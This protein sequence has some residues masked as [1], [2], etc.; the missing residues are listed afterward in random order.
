MRGVIAPQGNL[1]LAAVLPVALALAISSAP[2]LPAGPM[3]VLHQYASVALSP[4]GKLIASVETVRKPNATTEEHGAVVVRGI[5]GEVHAR[6][7]PCAKCR[8]ADIAWSSEGNRFAF[9]ASADGVATLYGATADT[10]HK[11]RSTGAPDSFTLTKVVDVKGLIASPRWSPDDR[12][13]AVLATVGAHKESGATRAGAREVGEIGES[14]DSQRIAT[15]GASGG[16][17]KF[18]SPDG[19]FVYEYGWMPDGRGFLG[20]AARGNGDDNWWIAKLQFFALDGSAKVVAAPSMQMDF[21][22]VSPDGRKVAFIGGLMSD[23]GSVGGDIYIV[24][25]DGGVPLDITPDFKGS[26]TSIQWRGNQLI[27]SL[28]VG[29]QMGTAQVDPSGKGVRRVHVQAATYG[30]ADGAVSLDRSGKHAALVSESFEHGPRIEYGTLGELRAITHDNDDQKPVAIAR[31]IKWQ[32]EGFSVQGWLL[33]PLQVQ[34]GKTYPMIVMIHGGPAA[35][36]TPGFF[37]DE[38]TADW[39][40]AGYFVFMP[41]PRG[42]Y[43]QGEAFTRANVRDFGG[44]DLRDDL[45]GIDAVEKAAPIDDSRLGLYG[46]SYG[47]F[48]TMWVVTHSHRFKVAAAGAGIADWMAYYGEN[49][50]DKWMIPY[51]GASAYDDASIY[52]RLSPIRSIKSVRT[53]TFLYVGERDVE[54]PAEQTR[55]FWHGLRAMGVPT[56]LVVYADEGHHLM[57]PENVAD[58]NHRL[59]DW[60]DR[61]LK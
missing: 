31:D 42:S 51:F 40:R 18:V 49:G 36:V 57:K 10:A 6:L 17:L 50:I 12:T 23:F 9:T 16:E 2:E 55:E 4:D 29:G 30:A 25:V 20:T 58:L 32:S 3:G 24:D 8:Y 45:S 14:E 59:V 1:M 39:L 21:P 22:R 33:S 41:N 34:P 37:W 52:D 38:M 43:G 11:A 28:V 26:F 15:V 48:M 7:D 56:S 61:Y 53:P 60:F 27:A 47:G 44:G 13:I 54:C 19:T 5:D 46:R 35:V